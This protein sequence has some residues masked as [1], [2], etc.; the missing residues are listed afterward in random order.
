MESGAIARLHDLW[1]S[2][3]VNYKFYFLSFTLAFIFLIMLIKANFS[4]SDTVVL[5]QIVTE[6]RMQDYEVFGNN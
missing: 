6:Y 3:N 4:K 5:R 2:L 1:T